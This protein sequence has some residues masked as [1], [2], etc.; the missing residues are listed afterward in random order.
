MKFNFHI[1]TKIIMDEDCVAKNASLLAPLGNKALIVTG[2]HSAKANGAL[3]DVLNALSANGQS[4]ALFD[5]V[6]SNPTVDCVYEGAEFARHEKAD[7]IVA[8]GGGSPMDA[9]K[10]IAMLACEDIPKDKIFVG[11][12]KKRLPLCCIPTTAGTGSETTQYAILMNDEKQTKTSLGSP[13][14]FPDLALLDSKYME[15]LSKNVM[16]NTVIDAFSH[17]VEGFLSNR[18][19]AVSDALALEAIKVIAGIFPA[20]SEWR[21]TKDDRA[22]LLYASTLGGMVI[23]HTGT[24]AVHSMGYSLTYFKNV[25][26]GRANGLLL[27]EFLRFTEKER[28]DRVI[29]ILK[30][31]DFTSTNEFG[32][33]LASLLGARENVTQEEI[34]QYSSIASKAKNIKNCIVEPSEED[35]NSLYRLSFRL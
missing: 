5:K 29:P 2:A 18:A 9:S 28:P 26:H 24:T 17:S 12:Y 4:F 11:E 8:I 33:A 27:P 14:L 16:T 30:A 25:D 1:A 35:L 15:S 13:V 19:N 20:I 6:M 7:F 32:C 10:V 22:E 34:R 31:A 23:A 21:L 3:G